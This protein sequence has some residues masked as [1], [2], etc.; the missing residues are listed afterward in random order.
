MGAMRTVGWLCFALVI[1]CAIDLQAQDVDSSSLPFAEDVTP[2]ESLRPFGA[3]TI[4]LGGPASVPAQIVEDQY[5]GPQYRLPA[6]D[7]IFPRWNSFRGHL[8]NELRLQVGMDYNVL[9]QTASETLTGNDDAASAIFRLYSDWTLFGETDKTSGSLISKAENR[10]RYSTQIAPAQ[11]G[12]DA[13]YL[14]IPGT[15][16]N[17]N[18]GAISNLY[19]EQFLCDGRAGFVVGMLEPDSF[20]D[21]LG[22]ANPW[23]TFQNFSVL[24][25]PTIPFPDPVFGAGAG[26]TFNDQWLVKGGAYDTNNRFGEFEFF[27]NGGELFTHGEISWSPSR[28]ERYLKEIHVTAWHTDRREQANVSESQGIAMGG[29]WTFADRWMTIFRAGW[30]DGGAPLMHKSLTTGVLRYVAERGDLAG[31]AM[32]WEDPTDRA[33]GEQN[34]LECFYRLQLAKNMAVTPSLQVLIDPALNP[35]SNAITLFGLRIRSTF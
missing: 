18:G 5:D 8:Q 21:V 16:F 14:G 20:V 26:F 34:T 33:L 28:A 12:F 10:H 11:I 32:T 27:P 23:T 24:V 30:A 25:N 31:V 19:W 6:I 22:Y 4:G 2:N 29:N 9:Y 7:S 13:G 15:L 17:D 1:L 3:S 35:D